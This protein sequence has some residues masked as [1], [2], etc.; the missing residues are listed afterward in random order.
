MATFHGFEDINAWQNARELTQRIYD[1]S[2]H[3]PFAKDFPL[4]DQ[5]RRASIS[6]IP[7]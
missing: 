7:T 6:I 2:G 1:A 4:R 3:G 5:I